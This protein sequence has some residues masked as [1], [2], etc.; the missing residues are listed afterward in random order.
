MKTLVVVA[1]PNI[2]TSVVNKRWIEELEQ[3][4]EDY[5]I[6]ELYQAY[7]S[8]K[9]VA[10]KERYL[11]ESHDQLVLQFPIQWFN[12]PSLLKK[13]LDEVFD[14]GWA[15][16]SNGGDK[17]KNKKIALAVS[18]GIRASDYSED[19]RY[20]HPL[21]QI[22]LPFKTTLLYCQAD[23]R[24]IHAFYGEEKKPGGTEEEALLPAENELER[25]TKAY[26]TFLNNL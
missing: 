4:P 24:S 25:N 13:W 26:L 11:I 7:P 1:H 3:Y 20:G 8:E 5:T 17:L 14:Y 9:I 23:Y 12:C 10:E 19:G 18:A 22:L 16:G 2:E 6:H 21:E 15:Y